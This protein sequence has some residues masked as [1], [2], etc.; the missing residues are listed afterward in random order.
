MFKLRNYIFCSL[1]NNMRAFTI[2]IKYAVIFVGTVTWDTNAVKLF[3][4]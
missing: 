1:Y 3:P 4:P 2:S